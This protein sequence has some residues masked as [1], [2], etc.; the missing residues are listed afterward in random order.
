[1]AINIHKKKIADNGSICKETQKPAVSEN[2]SPS[3]PADDMLSIKRRTTT[4]E[5]MS[6]TSPK[7]PNNRPTRRESRSQPAPANHSSESQ[8]QANK[9]Q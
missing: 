3:N 9:L 2:E 4:A 5:T 7:N 6:K 8:P 1:M